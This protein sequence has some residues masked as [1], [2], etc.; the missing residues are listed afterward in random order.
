M[1]AFSGGK[2]VRRAVRRVIRQTKRMVR[3]AGA[4]LAPGAA[5]AAQLRQIAARG[6][7]AL[8]G[9][10]DEAALAAAVNRLGRDPAD[11]LA[12]EWFL[13]LED[14]R[15]ELLSSTSSILVDSS[16]AST[17][18]TTVAEVCRR[19]SK[20]PAW[21]SLLYDIVRAEKP[22]VA[23]E[24]GTSVGISGSYLGAAL[25]SNGRGRLVT[26]EGRADVAA[27]A[28]RGFAELGLPVEV[29]VGRFDDT[30][31][32]TLSAHA[33]IDLMFIDGNH[34]EEPTIGYFEQALP[35]L[36]RRALVV[37][38]DIRWS[39]GME[40]AWTRLRRHPAVETAID[41][42]YIGLVRVASTP[43]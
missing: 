23:L 37:F 17:E 9:N 5:E 20:K 13:R 4:R 18:T 19:T 33:P 24:M 14:R 25:V 28:R 29:V 41:L 31:P 2:I 3:S 34:H 16:G 11:E 12:R 27:E 38:D 8:R 6:R 32:T 43:P 10:P 30:L 40:R 26:L 15:A 1:S 7:E 39:E 36:S 22:D 21:A 35:Y 42:Q